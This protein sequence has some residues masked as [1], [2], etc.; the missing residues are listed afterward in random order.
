MADDAGPMAD[1]GQNAATPTARL[2]EMMPLCATLGIEATA[3]A[4]RDEVV[5]TM[6][7][8][9]G[10]C[11]IGGALHGG[12]VMSLADAAGGLC[13]FLNLPDGASGTTT[14][15]SHT[16]FLRAVTAGEVEARARPV[17]A[18]RTVIV[19][20]TEVRDRAG[21]LIAKTVQSQ[22]VLRAG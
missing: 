22:A 9:P 15:Q 13:A 7:W 19:V 8:E 12:A 14:I 6:P 18:G 21:K 20:E 11:T 1:R 3:R 10:L 5:V 16:N 17:H 4:D 2:R